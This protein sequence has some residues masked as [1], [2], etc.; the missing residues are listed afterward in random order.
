MNNQPILSI[1]VV[2]Y[3]TKDILKECLSR[4]EI[5]SKDINKE[6]FV[7][8]NNSSDGST[9]MVSSEFPNFELI[10]NNKNLGFAAGNNVALKIASGRYVLLLNS[11]AFLMDDT[12]QKTI[13][14]MD[15][16][17]KAGILGIKLI[18]EDGSLQ[19]SA[20]NLPNPLSKF[21]VMSGVSDK[22]PSSRFFG[23]PDYKWWNHEEIKQVGWV[24]GAFF[25]IR[26]EVI[27]D[28]GLLDERYFM[29]FEEI[30]YCLQAALKGW[31]T[32]FYP[33]AKVIHIGGQSSSKSKQKIT[34]SGKQL[35]NFRV[36]SEFRYYRKNYGFLRLFLSA[37]VE[38]A[39]K[40][41]VLVKNI[42]SDD[43]ESII[44]KE[45]ARLILKTIIKTLYT[46]RLGQAK[47]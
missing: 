8:D 10:S 11:D 43:N 19:P 5:Y 47:I 22:F 44:K 41:T 27:D 42:L 32:I 16:N 36:K 13:N 7:V 17:E 21:L 40:S 14:Y 6:V 18:S 4:I 38:I 20:R 24:P 46:D 25:L 45:E 33:F 39:M 28:I 29:Y 3:N 2:S 35:I 34:Q 37:F 15:S 1:I 12:L 30:D 9:E 26:R 23:S 31:E